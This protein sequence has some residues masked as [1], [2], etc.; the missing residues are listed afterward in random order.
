MPI[1][2]LNLLTQKRYCSEKE[3]PL[4]DSILQKTI[5]S[6]PLFSFWSITIN[7]EYQTRYSY[8]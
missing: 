4:G 6:S 8:N 1:H 5:K 2:S 7:D 3:Y